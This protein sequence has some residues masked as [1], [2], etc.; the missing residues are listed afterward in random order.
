MASFKELIQSDKPVLIDFHADWCQPCK[1]LGPIVKQVKEQMGDRVSVLKIDVDR[2]PE[3]AAKLAIQGV[4]TLMIYRQGELKWRQSG[5]LSKE[6]I[7]QQ[8]NY[9]GA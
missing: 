8:L 4:P 5:V 2:N 9:F 3:L 1:V 7:I 6:A